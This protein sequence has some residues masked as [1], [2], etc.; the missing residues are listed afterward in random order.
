MLKAIHILEMEY[1]VRM[2]L[3]TTPA[4]CRSSKNFLGVKKCTID[5]TMI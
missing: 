4:Q 5:T 1:E 3:G 2:L